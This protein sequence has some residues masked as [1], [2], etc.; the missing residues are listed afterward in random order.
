MKLKLLSQKTYSKEKAKPP[1]KNLVKRGAKEESRKKEILRTGY[2]KKGDLVAVVK[3]A[4]AGIDGKNIFGECV[5]Y[6]KVYEP[7]LIAGENI[8]IDRGSY[9]YMNTDGI[10]EVSQDDSGIQ[11]LRGRPYRF[12]RFKVR[13]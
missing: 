7:R 8:R 10:V 12:G 6:E 5:P 3:S 11:Y 13:V 2:A 4:T 9:Y 1:A